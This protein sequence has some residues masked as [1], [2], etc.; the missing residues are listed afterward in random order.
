M[1]KEVNSGELIDI[2]EKRKIQAQKAF[3]R[4]K[5]ILSF[6]CFGVRRY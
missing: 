1:A 5:N 2:Q 6:L 3:K 4:R